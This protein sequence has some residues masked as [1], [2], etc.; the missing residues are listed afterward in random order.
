MSEP[1]T[2]PQLPGH[3]AVSPPPQNVGEGFKKAKHEMTGEEEQAPPG[4]VGAVQFFLERFGHM[5]SRIVLTVLYVLLIAPIGIFYRF[6]ANPFDAKY[7]GTSLV[8]WSSK[9]STLDEARRQG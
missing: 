2:E 3:G 7:R 6:I 5:M 8:P 1:A 9:N 4:L